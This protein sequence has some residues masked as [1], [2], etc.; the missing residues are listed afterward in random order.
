MTSVPP[1]TASTSAATTQPQT[2]HSRNPA[3]GA[4]LGRVEAT[5]PERVEEVVA[6]ARQV[7]PL[8][9]LL[10]VEDRARYMRRAA[11]AVIDEFDELAT[12]ARPRAG[13]PARGGR[14]HGAA[15]GARRAD[16]GR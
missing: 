14:E 13:P 2:L 11:Q 16:L 6:A 10:R 7:Q 4:I 5:A 1:E 15:G 12:A 3:T 9:A 8:W